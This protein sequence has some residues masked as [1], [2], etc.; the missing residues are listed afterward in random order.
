MNRPTTQFKPSGILRN[1]HMQSML[2]SSPP[3]R[4]LV[5]KRAKDYQAHSEL[6]LV[7]TLKGPQLL[8]KRTLA[9][10]GKPKARVI[11]LHGWEGSSDSSYLQALGNQLW[12]SGCET[13][14]LNFRD[15]GE[16]H[17]LNTELFHSCRLDEVSDAVKLLSAD[18]KVPVFLI[19]FSLGGN[20]ALRVS[21]RAHKFS[22]KPVH[23]FAISPVIR[24]KNVMQELEDG[25]FIYQKYFSNK[26]RASLRKKQ[27]IYPEHYDLTEFFKLK[28]LTAMTH[29]LVESYTEYDHTDDYFE[30][31]SVD[32]DYLSDLQ[33]P[34]T[35][36]TAKDD[37]II[38]VKDFALLPNN[39]NLKLE[40]HDHGGH[41]GFIKNW[42]LTSWLE[43]ELSD[44][45]DAQLTTQK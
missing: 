35:I 38:P 23:T 43:Q 19:G 40:I 3:R 8:A 18:S 21:A 34:T 10:N 4:W 7:L 41:C 14:R 45:I 12:Q 26:W 15:H 30:G 31:Y 5:N 25:L 32:G 28:G 11:L 9:R 20:F 24:P 27:D 42:R 33:I 36:I 16:T 6:E 17:Y 13:I 29:A 37:P 39:P 2:V 44:R 1:K 22:V